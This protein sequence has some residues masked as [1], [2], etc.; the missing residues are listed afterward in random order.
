MHSKIQRVWFSFHFHLNNPAD[1]ME[2]LLVCT[3]MERDEPNVYMQIYKFLV[4]M[5]QIKSLH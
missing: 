2:L 4:T 3:C 1:L 5:V